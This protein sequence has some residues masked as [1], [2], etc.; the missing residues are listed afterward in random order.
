MPAPLTW[1]EVFEEATRLTPDAL[2]PREFCAAMFDALRDVHRDAEPQTW[3]DIFDRA[4]ALTA[5]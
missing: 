2:S 1:G 3:K 4:T 5:A